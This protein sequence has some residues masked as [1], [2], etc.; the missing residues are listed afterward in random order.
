MFSCVL[1]IVVMYA[2]TY[3]KSLLLLLLSDSCPLIVAF[4]PA[5]AAA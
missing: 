3:S 1:L 2:I 4:A 5:S